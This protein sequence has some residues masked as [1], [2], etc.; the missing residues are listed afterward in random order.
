MSPS[1][2]KIYESRLKMALSACN[3]YAGIRAGFLPDTPSIVL[4]IKHQYCAIW[5]FVALLWCLLVQ[6][7]RTLDAGHSVASMFEICKYFLCRK[8]AQDHF[9]LDLAVDVMQI[10]VCD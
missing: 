2:S 1:N 8:L 7:S 6:E 3:E 5:V 4:T 10:N 9:H